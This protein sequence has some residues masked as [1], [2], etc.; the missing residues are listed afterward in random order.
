MFSLFRKEKL[1]YLVIGLFIGGLALRIVFFTVSC[2]T[3][4]PTGDEGLLMLQAKHIWQ[5]KEVPLL[6]WAQPYT[7]PLESYLNAPLTGLLPSNGFGARFLA[8]FW[9][10]FAC[11]C[12]LAIVRNM[13]SLRNVWPGYLL[14]LFPSSYWLM[15]QAAYAPPSYPSFIGL[16]FLAILCA[17]ESRKAVSVCKETLFVSVSG[18]SAG[19]SFSVALLAAPLLVGLGLFFGMAGDFRR[20]IRQVI[21]FCLALLVG[22]LPQILARLLIPGAYGAV[23]GYRSL[24]DALTSIWETAVQWGLP[25]AFGIRYSFFP[26]LTRNPVSTVSDFAEQFYLV[27]LAVFGLVVVFGVYR[28]LKDSKKSGW[29][30]LDLVNV[31]TVISVLGL[32]LFGVSNRA[33]S[34]SYRYLLPVVMSFPF[35]LAFLYRHSSRPLRFAI[36]GLTLFLVSLN[37]VHSAK[38]IRL[39]QTPDF[40]KI[41]AEV[42]SVQPVIDY[43]DEKNIT[44]AYGSWFSAHRITYATDERIVSGQY[45]N[46]RFFGW[47]TPYK[48]IIDSQGGNVAFVLDPTRRLNPNF[49]E[50]EMARAHPDVGYT[51]KQAGFYT[52]YSDFNYTPVVSETRIEPG[53]MSIRV[54]DNPG[55]SG[56]LLDGNLAVPWKSGGIQQRGM[57]IELLLAEPQLVSRVNL[58]YNN[59]HR[60]KAR[61]LNVSA[62][63]EGEPVVLRENI[64]RNGSFIELANGHP[65]AGNVVQPISLPPT[66]T[67]RLRVTIAEP[68][69][70]GEWVVD[71]IR[72]F[73]VEDQPDG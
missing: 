59:G 18:L 14:I 64:E 8:W 52:V 36:G 19:L 26:D 7:F 20:S 31:F 30:N 53:E 71:E 49:F 29:L 23:S 61:K 10:L 40:G 28:L 21:L 2:L 58:Y 25:G 48:E 62:E 33:L 43:L 67:K 72:L 1:P 69:E 47:P 22:L 27:W 45:Y 12:G 13:G 17:Q 38:L 16:M 46:E 73:R 70:S 65:V 63:V 56:L 6:F 50:K 44:Y 68:D 9:G 41:H 4:E 32:V 34:Q 54:S 35:W 37:L 24:P 39:W 11:L 57:Y 66:R 42:P 5:G 60:I 3:V 15:M 51:K 55:Q